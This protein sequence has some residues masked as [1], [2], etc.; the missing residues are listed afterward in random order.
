[1][2]AAHVGLKLVGKG[3][4]ELSCT[5]TVSG[6]CS[7]K[8]QLDYT[9]KS[10]VMLGIDGMF[11]VTPGFRLGLGYAVVPY[12]AIGS[13]PN[14]A[15]TQHLGHEHALNAIVEGLVPLK[16]RLAIALRA[17]GGVRMLVTGGDLASSTDKLLAE[18]KDSVGDHCEAARGPFFGGTLG[19]TAGVV[20][21]DKVRARFDLGVDRVFYKLRDTAHEYQP[22]TAL[23]E[24]R[25]DKQTLAGTRLWLLLGVEL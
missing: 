23:S 13:E 11:H 3:R 2:F 1:V 19:G 17:Q 7:R 15:T 12:A 24:K 18:C 5:D 4:T 14:E 6:L 10:W 8:P 21:G 9:D 25:T 20:L 22:D 16:P